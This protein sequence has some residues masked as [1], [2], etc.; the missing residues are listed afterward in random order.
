MGAKNMAIV[1][2]P[3]ILRS[4]VPPRSPLETHD[5]GI[6]VCQLLIE[7]SKEL[8]GA[9][10]WGGSR[11]QAPPPP[12]TQG[13]VVAEHTTT[14]QEE[15][16]SL[17]QEVGEPEAHSLAALSMSHLD[18]LHTAE[19]DLE[20]HLTAFTHAWSQLAAVTPA[21]DPAALAKLRAAVAEQQTQER[22]LAAAKSK[23]LSCISTLVPPPPAR[24][25]HSSPTK[26]ASGA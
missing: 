17:E 10:G 26:E 12:P 18:A 13:A 23:V 14:T 4:P 9:H 25:R 2:A 5:K 7:H 15:Q 6:A 16:S 8:F 22:A 19:A 3:N 20:R 24:S 21:P 11:R 1:L